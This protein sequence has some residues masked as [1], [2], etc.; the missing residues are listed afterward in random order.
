LKNQKKKK[1]KEK[2]YKDLYQ[3]AP[4]TQIEGYSEP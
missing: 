2:R 3:E 1:K 4:V